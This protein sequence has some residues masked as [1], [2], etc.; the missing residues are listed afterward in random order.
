MPYAYVAGLSAGAASAPGD[1]KPLDSMT[2]T[3]YFGTTESDIRKKSWENSLFAFVMEPAKLLTMMDDLENL[4]GNDLARW[5]E[6]VQ[7]LEET[8]QGI[9]LGKNRLQALNKKVGDRFTLYGVNY[10]GID[11]EVEIVGT[12]PVARYD[13]SSALRVDFFNRT[14]DAYEQANKGQPSAGR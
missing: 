3:F 10:R 1:L 9:V 8:P 13:T 5:K 14:M 11:L 4:K 6:T 2:W 7:K 12:F